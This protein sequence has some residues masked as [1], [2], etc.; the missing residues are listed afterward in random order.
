MKLL[1]KIKRSLKDNDNI[2]DLKINVICKIKDIAWVI[3][4]PIKYHRNLMTKRLLRNT[5]PDT[6]DDYYNPDFYQNN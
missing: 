6:L 2:D 3:K 4:H 1:K 5:D